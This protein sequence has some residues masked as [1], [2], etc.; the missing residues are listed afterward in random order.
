MT[1]RVSWINKRKQKKNCIVAKL[2]MAEKG[3]DDLLTSF[4]LRARALWQRWKLATIPGKRSVVDSLSDDRHV[5]FF[6]QKESR[7]FIL[8]SIIIYIVALF[9][10]L[11]EFE[12]YVDVI[13]TFV[14]LR[15][16]RVVSIFLGVCVIFKNMNY[17]WSLITQFQWPLFV[18]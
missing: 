3:G 7:K 1:V 4:R 8:S 15:R 13:L 12:N 6:F 17:R 16:K 9:Q 18:L 10:S 2:L 11:L 14:L 5:L